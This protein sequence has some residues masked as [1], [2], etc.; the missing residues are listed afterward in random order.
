M[1]C[2]FSF[3]GD[4]RGGLSPLLTERKE[5]PAPSC[6]GS[7]DLVA[8]RVGNLMG[9]NLRSSLGHAREESRHFWIGS[10]GV[11][12]CVLGFVPQTDSERFLSV[13]SNEGD[14]S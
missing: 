3:A 13:R 12:F 4:V 6:Y 1:F 7:S 5:L 9:L 14:F 11:S 2:S 8:G 10:A